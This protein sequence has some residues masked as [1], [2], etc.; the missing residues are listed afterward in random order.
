MLFMQDLMREAAI[1]AKQSG[2]RGVGARRIRKVREVSFLF[3]STSNMILMMR[4]RG[5]CR[6]LGDDGMG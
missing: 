1:S 5:V 3:S 6:S 4:Y 2:E